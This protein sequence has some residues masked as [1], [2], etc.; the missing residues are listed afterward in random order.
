MLTSF[1]FNGLSIP[2]FPVALFRVISWHFVVAKNYCHTLDIGLSLEYLNTNIELHGIY[3]WVDGVGCI[4]ASDPIETDNKKYH[5]NHQFSYTLSQTNGLC[6]VYI[7]K[8][9]PRRER[10]REKGRVEARETK[11]KIKENVVIRRAMHD[12]YVKF[13]RISDKNRTTL[14]HIYSRRWQT[15][16]KKIQTTHGIDS[17]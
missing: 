7:H 17:D 15:T 1:K 14:C 11:N 10:E 2:I 5:F 8:Y 9:S 13:S 16:F 12:K 4:H 3:N 6:I